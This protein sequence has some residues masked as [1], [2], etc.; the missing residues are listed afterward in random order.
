[1][2]KR[3]NTFGATRE[4]VLNR[5]SDRLC[6][7]LRTLHREEMNCAATLEIP[8]SSSPVDWTR[9]NGPLRVAREE[10]MFREF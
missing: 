8:G 4:L 9:S 6:H 7:Q 3:C 5:I 1:M 10:V 2:T